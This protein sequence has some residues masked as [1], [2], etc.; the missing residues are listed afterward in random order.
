MK[1]L[2][3]LLAVVALFAPA[4]DDDDDPVNPS[5]VLPLRFTAD[6][7]ASNEVPPVTNADAAAT[8]RMTVTFTVARDAV[9]NITAVTSSDFVVDMA[10]FPAGTV[11]VGAHIHEAPAG[12]TAP[13][14]IDTG[15]KSGEVTLGLGS[16]SFAKTLTSGVSVEQVQN[17]A[18]N[19]SGYYFN[20]HTP[21]NPSGAIRAQLTLVQ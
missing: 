12:Q 10:G 2:A 5:T 7:K 17:M 11:L 3:L 20:V 18:K 4:C 13:I 6:L 16:G 8:G 19:P 21:L 14:Y 1:R 15:L 9:L